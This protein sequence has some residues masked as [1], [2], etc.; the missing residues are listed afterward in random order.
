MRTDVLIT[1]EASTTHRHG[2][3]AID[4]LARRTRAKLVI[5]G[6]HHRSSDVVTAG[7]MRVVG[8]AKAEVFQLPDF[9][10]K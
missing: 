9:R 4:E 3:A 2:F 6:H 10:G 7:G 5:H 1:H 8:L